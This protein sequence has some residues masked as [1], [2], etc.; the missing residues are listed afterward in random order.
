LGNNYDELDLNGFQLVSLASVPEL[1]SVVLM[2]L[3][4]IVLSGYVLMRR[5]RSQMAPA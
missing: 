5:R 1:S 3:G 4:A 2:G